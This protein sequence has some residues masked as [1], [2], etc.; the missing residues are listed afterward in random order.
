MD[1]LSAERISELTGEF[2]GERSQDGRPRIS[3]DVLE[4]MKRVT[5]EEAWGVL[6]GHDY[7]FQ[8]EGEWINLHPDR[9][10]TGRAVTCRYVPHRPDLNQ[11]V[12]KV[13]ANEGRIGGQNSWV[14]DTLVTGDVLVVELFGKIV[15]GT[16]I[17]DNLGTA[18]ASNTGGTGL[19]VDGSIRDTQR[20]RELPINVFTKG[21][22]P[23]G[24]G[25][26]TMTEINGPIRIGQAS[27]LPGDIVLGTSS[28]IVFIP[29]KLAQQ[30]VESSESTRL[31]D[32]WGKQSIREGRYTPGEIDRGWTDEMNVE[33]QS[34]SK[35][36][37]VNEL[38][39]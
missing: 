13:G 22:H 32:Y 14:I 1:L 12:E 29:P 19:V 28:G 3:D 8:Y 25:E 18:I 20:V 24:I 2:D 38:E 21:L 31:R 34:W 7:N 4:R 6:A 10:L 36:V 9:V 35:T 33:F 26:V 27:V 23:T 17:G 15:R 11:V 39:Y 5:T 37:D 30:V 16:F